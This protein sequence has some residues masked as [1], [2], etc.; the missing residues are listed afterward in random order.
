MTTDPPPVEPTPAATPP[1]APIKVKLKGDHSQS[2][3]KRFEVKHP[4]QARQAMNQLAQGVPKTVIARQAGITPL[5]LDAFVKRNPD[6]MA[7]T[8]RRIQRKTLKIADRS[9]KNMEK[10]MDDAGPIEQATMG[11]AMMSMH[12]K[13]SAQLK[14]GA[15]APPPQ[16]AL[17]PEVMRE[18]IRG[19]LQAGRD[20]ALA[21][22]PV[23]VEPLDVEVTENKSDD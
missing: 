20:T 11:K 6:K 22:A 15:T 13:A 17:T 9:L 1:V 7:R 8:L 14:D 3:A 18:L 2:H 21:A 5:T 10:T 16:N 23:P 12:E 19:L 4:V